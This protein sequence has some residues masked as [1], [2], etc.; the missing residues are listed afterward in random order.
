M[1]NTVAF[2]LCTVVTVVSALVSLG[3]ST[4]ALTGQNGTARTT[5]SYALTRSAALAVVAVILLIF[6]AR[7]W[8]PAVAV[9]MVLV[10]TGDA[11]VGAMIKDK[12]KTIGPALTALA[13][14]AALLLYLAT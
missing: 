13:N 1:N 11:A 12:L 8:L 10:Q 7:S 9:C 2:W 5:A 4:R 3:Y 6:A 14:L